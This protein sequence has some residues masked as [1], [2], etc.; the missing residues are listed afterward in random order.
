M[1]KHDGLI[2]DKK[3]NYNSGKYVF[4]CEL[5]GK[6]KTKNVINLET[7]HINFQK[8]FNNGLHSTKS[9]IKKNSKYNL[10][11]VCNLCHDN[12]HTG[13]ININS[14]QMTSKG[15]QIIFNKN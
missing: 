5:C 12:I 4:E 6:K 8:D 13:D 7:H 3:S 14:I 2:S 1:D 15:K 11:V 9:H 10:L